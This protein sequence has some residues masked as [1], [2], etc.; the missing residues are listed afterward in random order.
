[1]TDGE[2]SGSG[3]APRGILPVLVNRKAGLGGADPT[4]PTAF[5]MRD[6]GVQAVV[7]PVAP[8][9]IAAEVAKIAARGEPM[10]AVAGGDG[11]QRAAAGALVGTGTAL[12][13]I[14]T[15]TL[16]HFARR[17]GLPDVAAAAR[18]AADGRDVRLP[19]GVLDDQ[20]FLNT[21]TFGLYADVVQR[22]ERIRR[23]I[24]KWG[25]AGIAFGRTLSSF[26]TFRIT[27]NARGEEI[28]RETPLLWVG[29]GWGSFPLVHESPDERRVPELEIV[30]LRPGGRLRALSLLLRFAV[31]L[32]D[33][34]RLR[35][36]PDLEFLHAREL[37]I[38]ARR[39]IGVTLDGEAMRCDSP[40]VVAVQEEAVLV[41]T[42]ADLGP[43]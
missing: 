27:L 32:R 38:H 43:G 9:R 22:R 19:T 15:G 12:L 20:I 4:V 40:I 7:R 33:P 24:G 34:A 1:M 39:R 31:L 18:V 42:P 3:A 41:R 14:P 30:V 11:T 26:R 8:E 23:H 16:N 6:A 2:A 13:P 5:A 28:T 37:V 10:V 21:A 35:D 17:V 25:A 29:L 36:D